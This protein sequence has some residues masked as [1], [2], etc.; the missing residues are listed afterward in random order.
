MRIKEIAR[1]DSYVVERHARYG[2]CVNEQVEWVV[3]LTT[4]GLIASHCNTK[5]DALQWLTPPTGA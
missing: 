4:S 1:N 3:R 5:R 2:S